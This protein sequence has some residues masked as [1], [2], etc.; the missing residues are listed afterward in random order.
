MEDLSH[1][2]RCY[3][4][5]VILDAIKEKLADMVAAIFASE[6]VVYR[7]AGL[8]DNRLATLDRSSARYYERWPKRSIQAPASAYFLNSGLRFFRKAKTLL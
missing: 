7:V 3:P 6:S 5:T 2:L 8:L 4:H 1:I